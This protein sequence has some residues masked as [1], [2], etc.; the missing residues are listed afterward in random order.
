MSRHADVVVLG[1]GH[2]GLT[3]AAYLARAGWSVL[4]LEA[5]EEVGGTVATEEPWPG[6]L[7]PVA[8]PGLDCLH[9][10][11]VSELALEEHGLHL[12]PRRGG[13]VVLRG[14]DRPLVLDAAR[15]AGETA[16]GMARRDLEA[17]AAFERLRRTVTGGLAE[18]MASPLPELDLRA[19]KLASLLRSAWGLRGLFGADREEILRLLPMSLRDVLDERFE[20]EALKA[21]IAGPALAAAWMGPRSP[22][23]LWALLGQ[24]PA[25]VPHL[26]SPPLRAAG[27]PGGLTR[28]LAAAARRDGAEIRTSS[29][30]TR[31]LV[32]AAGAAAVVLEDGTEIGARCVVSALDPRRT[33]LDLVEPGRLDPEVIRALQGLRCRGNVALVRMALDAPPRFGAGQSE[34]DAARAGRLQI[35]STL[36]DLERAWDACKYGQ[37]AERPLLELSIPSTA[38]PTLAPDGKAV[39]T[40]WVQYAPYE[41]AGDGWQSAGSELGEKVTALVEEHAPGLTASILHRDVLT[42]ADIESRFG[43]TQGCLHHVEPALDQALWLRPLARWYRYRTPIDGLYLCGPGTHPG[44]GVT[45]LPGRCAARQISSEAARRLP[46]PADRERSR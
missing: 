33:L 6:F 27:G 9:P 46:P 18:L 1:A 29:V 22:G 41:L 28:A 15:P 10:R 32:G 21:A 20:D 44:G 31:I 8:Y 37:V 24:R 42:P 7:L 16:H 40:V 3:A 19:T 23:S 11:V 30:A 4:V 36:D 38:D 17:L 13:T 43:L 14:G 34:G 25:W 45:G 2:N 5:R 35:G 39:M 26:F 12:L